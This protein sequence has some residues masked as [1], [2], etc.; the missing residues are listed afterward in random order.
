MKILAIGAHPDDIEIFMFG[1][2]ASYL[3]RGDKISLVIATDGSAGTVKEN[4]NLCDIRSKEAIKGLSSLGN[5]VFLGL[6]DGKLANSCNVREKICQIIENEK[7]DLI[8]THA[9]EDYHPDHRALSLYVTDEAGFK[10]PVIFVDTLMGINFKPDF[11]VD[12]TPFFEMKKK[13]ILCHKSQMPEKFV[14]VAKLMNR[15]RS[16]Q[17]N[18]PEGHYAEAYRISNRFPFSDIRS[19]IPYEPKQRPF[20]QNGLD[21]FV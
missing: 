9:P 11:Y 7:P 18:A 21:S 20:Y 17:C 8:V 6:T 16:A 14:S 2:L 10:C 3:K 5:P 19:L 1:L 15:F 12:I 13:A 4:I